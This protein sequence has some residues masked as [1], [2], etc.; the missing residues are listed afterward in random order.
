MSR[1]YWTILSP[2]VVCLPTFSFL[3]ALSSLILPFES[4]F[5]QRLGP[6]E[7]IHWKGFRHILSGTRDPLATWIVGS[8]CTFLIRKESSTKFVSIQDLDSDP[9]YEIVWIYFYIFHSYR[10]GLSF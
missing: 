1:W 6:I 3:N 7:S 2:V 4:I 8:S 10:V 5:F 9:R